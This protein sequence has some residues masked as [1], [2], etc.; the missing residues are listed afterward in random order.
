MN[1]RWCWGRRRNLT[2]PF[3]ALQ[4][5]QPQLN[6]PAQR[7]RRRSGHAHGAVAELGDV[8]RGPDDLQ[9]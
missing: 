9:P 7:F 8:V 1:F 5:A 6:G 3:Q 4:K 2:L